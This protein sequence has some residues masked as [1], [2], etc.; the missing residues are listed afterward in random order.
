MRAEVVDVTGKAVAAQARLTVMRT[1]HRSGSHPPP[2][3]Y[4][5]GSR[6]SPVGSGSGTPQSRSS[7]TSHVSRVSAA[8]KRSRRKSRASLRLPAA[9]GLRSRS[10]VRG[11]PGSARSKSRSRKGKE[12]AQVEPN[13]PWVSVDVEGSFLEME[14]RLARDDA[15]DGQ[16]ESDG[17]GY[18]DGDAS[19][20]EPLSSTGPCSHTLPSFYTTDR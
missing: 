5:S 20:D 13:L 6:T 2:S 11:E 16:M 1:G 4:S 12:P 14:P 15:G 3:A 10:T 8:R 9:V 17:N 19:V 18:D 7:I